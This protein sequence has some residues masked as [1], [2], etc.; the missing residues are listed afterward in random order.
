MHGII[1]DH[2]VRSGRITDQEIKEL[3]EQM[4]AAPPTVFSTMN[5]SQNLADPLE[6][7]L[8]PKG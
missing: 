6:Q 3:G 7:A 8:N 5:H 1:G 2:V 4:A